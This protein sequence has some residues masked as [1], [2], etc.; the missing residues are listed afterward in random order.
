M[1]QCS[2]IVWM[3]S[4]VATFLRTWNWLAKYSNISAN[5]HYGVVKKKAFL[6]FRSRKFARISKLHSGVLYIIVMTTAYTNTYRQCLNQSKINTKWDCC[7]IQDHFCLME[8]YTPTSI[9]STWAKSVSIYWC[10]GPCINLAVPFVVGPANFQLK[11][12]YNSTM[13]S[14]LSRKQHLS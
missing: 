5:L 1:F 3:I 12:Q 11:M 4:S 9:L 13:V 2:C 10:T 8:K 14:T 6:A 7:C